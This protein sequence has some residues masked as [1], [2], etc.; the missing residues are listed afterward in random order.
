MYSF[1]IYLYIF[2]FFVIWQFEQLKGGEKVSGELRVSLEPYMMEA[3]VDLELLC[4]GR[5]VVI[6]GLLWYFVIDKRKH[7]LDDIAKG[8]GDQ[9]TYLAKF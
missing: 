1:C 7:E 8:R 2:D 4:G 5:E 3:G 6:Q 9:V